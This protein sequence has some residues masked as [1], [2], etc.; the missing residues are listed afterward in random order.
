MWKKTMGDTVKL[1]AVNMRHL[2]AFIW[3][4]IGGMGIGFHDKSMIFQR[5][6]LLAMSPPDCMAVMALTRMKQNP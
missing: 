6:V 5:L 4:N 1:L 2:F 3:S